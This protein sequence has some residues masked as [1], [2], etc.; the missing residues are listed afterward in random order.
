M[1][2]LEALKPALNSTKWAPPCIVPDSPNCTAKTERER[3]RKW[4]AATA[5]R[6][7]WMEGSIRWYSGREEKMRQRDRV[8][9]REKEAG[10]AGGCKTVCVRERWQNHRR[11]SVC[12]VSCLCWRAFQEQQKLL[13]S[14]NVDALNPAPLVSDKAN[15]TD[16][17]C[18]LRYTYCCMCTLSRRQQAPFWNGSCTNRSF[19]PLKTG[20]NKP[21]EAD[22][23]V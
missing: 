13:S 17:C 9:R 22:N 12:S 23:Y 16:S 18:C 8:T 10:R 21:K 11:R 20:P 19:T 2:L 15:C 7:G 6:K 5:E 3:S 14:L 1:N 4:W